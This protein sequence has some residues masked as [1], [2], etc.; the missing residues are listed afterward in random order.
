MSALPNGAYHIY[1]GDKLP[2]LVAESLYDYIYE[3][4]EPH[5][6]PLSNY[7]SARFVR[8]QE[9]IEP[10]ATPIDTGRETC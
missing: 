5:P 9:V 7:A 1:I 6:K 2:P 10:I 3:C 8:L 4:G